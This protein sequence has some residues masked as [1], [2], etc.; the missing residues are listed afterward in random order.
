MAGVVAAGHDKTAEAGRE[1]LQLGGNAFDG[2]VAAMLAACVV[3]PTLT[4][5]GGGGF[6]L[7]H[8]AN[9]QN[10]LFDFL[11]RRRVVASYRPRSIFIRLK[12]ILAIRYRNFTLV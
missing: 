4:S 6:L 3:E 1:I 11:P 7:A 8:S 5:L 9:G 2:A 10:T 12:L